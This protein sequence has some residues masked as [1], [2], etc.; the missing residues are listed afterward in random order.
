MVQTIVAQRMGRPDLAR[1]ALHHDSH[2][3][4]ACD[5]PTPPLCQARVRQLPPL[6]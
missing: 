4:F 5:L 2:E 3:A 1:A 6:D